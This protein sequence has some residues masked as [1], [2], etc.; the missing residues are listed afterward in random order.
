MK[1]EYRYRKTNERKAALE[2]I[3]NR[4]AM[5]EATAVLKKGG[6][7]KNGRWEVRKPDRELRQEVNA[8]RN[9]CYFK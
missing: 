4:K 7:F 6:S 9:L 2:P 8:N 1:V 3:C 5:K